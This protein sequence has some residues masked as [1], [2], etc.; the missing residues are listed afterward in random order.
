MTMGDLISRKDAIDIMNAKGDV[1]QGTPKAVFYGAAHMLET[2]PAAKI[3]GS[4]SDGYHTFDELYHHRAV[5]FSVIVKAYPDSA[6]K[7]KRHHDGTMYDGMFIV[8]INTPWGQATY[9]YDIDPYWDIFECRELEC[10]PKWDGHSPDEAIDRI[11][12]LLPLRHGHWIQAGHDGWSSYI[13]CSKCKRYLHD[14]HPSDY[15]FC[16]YCGAKMDGG[17]QA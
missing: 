16:P 9:H 1:A 7:S 3:N 6:W 14:I 8:G 15:K 2:L 4:T 11:G 5:L 13:K 17:D 10:A 12:K